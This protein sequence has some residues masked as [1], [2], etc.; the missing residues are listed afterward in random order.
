MN[1]HSCRAITLLVIATVLGACSTAPTR[2]AAAVA[3]QSTSAPSA[4]GG[5]CTGFGP[6]TP[7]DIDQTTGSNQR[8]FSMAPEYPNLNLCNV[9]FHNN[10]E[11]KARDFSIYAGPG[12]QGMGGGYRC[13]ISTTLSA[14]ERQAPAGKICHGLT[15]GD[16]IE[17]HWV[18]SSCDVKPGATLGACLSERCA[19]PQLRVETQVFTLVNDASAMNF[20]DFDYGNTVVNGYHQ[21]KALPLGTGS[22]VQFLGSTTG[23]KYNESVCSPL[24]VSWSV[25]PMCAKADIN[26]VGRWCESNA[27]DEDHAHGVRQLVTDP[28][29]L[30]EIK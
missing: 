10:A 18:Y 19:N 3:Q 1:H 14:A 24:Q 20:N 13:N 4:D 12:D 16:T 28:R 27:F 25:R 5:G 26:S 9:H 15:P 7:R 6:Q 30:S 21:A 29:L 22:P 2:P 11:H 23:P 17:V 8:L